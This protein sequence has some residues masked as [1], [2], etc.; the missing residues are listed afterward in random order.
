MIPTRDRVEPA[1]ALRS[2]P[3]RSYGHLLFMRS[4][5][6]TTGSTEFREALAFLSHIEVISEVA[7]VGSCPGE[8]NYSAIGL[9]KAVAAARGEILCIL[10]NDIEV[11]HEEWLSILVGLALQPDIGVVGP[12]CCMTI[13]RSSTQECCLTTTSLHGTVLKAYRHSSGGWRNS[14][15]FRVPCLR[16][17]AHVR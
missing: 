15:R 13:T 1:P 9:N 7:N 4:L 16:S 11:I 10:N 8:C 12:S 17:R 5:W 2:F 6:P 14:R 3:R